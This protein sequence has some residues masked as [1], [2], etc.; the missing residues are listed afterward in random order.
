MFVILF[1][2]SIFT[3]KFWFKLF[4]QAKQK[5]VAM[6]LFHLEIIILYIGF[7]C[8]YYYRQETKNY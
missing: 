2:N 1:Y 7:Y 6:S 4:F 5:R 8:A 3:L